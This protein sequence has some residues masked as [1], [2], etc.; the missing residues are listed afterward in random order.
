MRHLRRSG[1]YFRVCD[2][3]WADC[4]TTEPSKI[5]GGRWNAPGR[6]GVLYLCATRAVAAANARW[7]YERDGRFTLFDRAPDRR[8]HLQEFTIR[9]SRFVDA[10]TGTGLAALGLPRTYPIGAS[11]AQCRAAGAKAYDAGERGIACR[12]A[13]EATR[14]HVIGEELAVFDAARELASAGRRLAFRDWYPLPKLA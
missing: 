13:A 7:I 5:F 6:F 11:Y 12:S 8:P 10:V 4:G 14:S 2:A 1:R 3:T 9:P